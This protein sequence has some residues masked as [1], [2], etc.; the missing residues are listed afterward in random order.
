MNQMKRFSQTLIL[1]KEQVLSQEEVPN[2]I[3]F[4][5]MIIQS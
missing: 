5:D 4:R 3:Q 2:E 1:W